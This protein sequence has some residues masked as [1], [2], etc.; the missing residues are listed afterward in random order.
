L[1]I[2]VQDV[3]R[4]E[5]ETTDLPLSVL[6]KWAE[7]LGL[8]VAELVGEPGDSLSTPLF[9]RAHLVRVMKTAMA[10]LERTGNLQ[11]KRMAQTLVDQLM[12][13]RPELRGV[14]AWH[15]IGTRRSLDEL[16]I[17]AERS[18]SDEVFMDVVD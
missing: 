4:Q 10:I 9:N 12:E 1:G 13:I 6:H 14:S 2:T 5:C 7:V 18:F 11:T 8:P 15:A 3:S 16:G 17:A